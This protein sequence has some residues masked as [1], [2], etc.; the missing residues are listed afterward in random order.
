MSGRLLPFA[1]LLACAAFPVFS[2]CALHRR[3]GGTAQLPFGIDGEWVSPIAREHPLA[4]RIFGVAAGSEVGAADLHSA[5][6]GADIVLLGEQHD[7]VDHHRLQAALLRDLVDAGR[8]PAVAFEQLDLEDQPAVDAVLRERGAADPARLATRLAERVDW[9]KSGWPP[10]DE[11]RGIFEVALAAHLDLRAA[12]LSRPAMAHVLAQAPGAAPSPS[13]PR[14]ELPA[15]ERRAMA[16]EIEQSHCGYANERMIAAMIEAQMYRDDAMARVIANA[17]RT[18]GAVLI[19]GFGHAR[20]DYGVPLYLGDRAPGAR[21]VSVGLLEVVPERTTAGEY[22]E[23][24]GVER[25]PFDYVV[26]T[27]RADD[28]DPCEKFREGLEKMKAAHGAQ[29]APK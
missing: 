28:E 20:K 10:F 24:L 11:Y 5:L 4:G 8:R 2:G 3:E 14:V 9:A 15:A 26:F 1:V 25:L 17:V 12:N 6:L 22:G 29:A 23:L 13:A 21:V 7:N 18:D 16:T 19:A 27:P